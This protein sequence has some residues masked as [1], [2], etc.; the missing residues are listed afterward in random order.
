MKNETD[1]MLQHK[2]GLYSSGVPGSP[3]EEAM[4]PS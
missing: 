2:K 1:R 3:V 4:S